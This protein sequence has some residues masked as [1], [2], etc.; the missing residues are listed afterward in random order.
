MFR[1]I[2]RDSSSKVNSITRASDDYMPRNMLSQ[3]LHVAAVAFN[4]MWLGEVM[5][6]DWDMFYVSLCYFYQLN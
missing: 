4:S 6:P 5:V 3:T 2:F 1:L